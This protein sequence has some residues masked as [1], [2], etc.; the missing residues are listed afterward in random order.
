MAALGAGR[1]IDA[2]HLAIER[3]HFDAAAECGLNHRDWHAAVNVGAFALE[4]LVTA[5]RQEDVE[6]ACGAAARAGLALAGQANA[7]A[8]LDAGRNGDLE[9]LVAPHAALARAAA[10]GL[11]D[12]L[13]CAV[14][15]MAGALDGEEALL[16]A[17]ATAAV[18]GWAL[19]RLGAGL[20]T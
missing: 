2:R 15:G 6:I 1:N 3:R 9:R 5:H 12:H 8:V 7:R 13:A 19:L 16:R 17:Q 11:V 14:A 20:G 10:A 4:Q 18:A